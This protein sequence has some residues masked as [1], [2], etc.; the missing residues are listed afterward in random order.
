[1]KKVFL[2]SGML[3]VGVFTVAFLLGMW[4]DSL[5]LEE[6]KITLTDIDNLWNDA[7]LI[8]SFAGSASCE[9]L[10]KE[11]H[12]LGDRIYA[13]GLKLEQ[14]ELA[15]RFTPSLLQEKKRYALL[16]LQFWLNSIELKKKCNADYATLI[17]FYSQNEKSVE[18]KIMDNLLWEFK[19]KCGPRTV[20]ITLPADL[21][22]ST[23]STIKNNFNITK[24]PSLLIN[25]SV[26]LKNSV[27]MQELER[28][29]NCN[30]IRL[31]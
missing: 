24:T 8:A 4:F 3:T 25:E 30:S 11:N 18:Q 15:N 28:Y 20:Y 21:D 5:R 12:E 26:V 9:F 13:E 27:T 19:Q 16:D 1:M 6:V 14:Y 17:Y 7:R 31:K 2:K 29:V 22:I 10:L 23:I